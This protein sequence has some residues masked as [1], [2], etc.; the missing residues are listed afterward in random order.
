LSDTPVDY[1]SALA[2]GY[3][4]IRDV[5]RVTGV[6]PVTL[7]AWER[8]Y[9]LVVPFRTPKG[10]RLYAPEQVQLIQQVLTWL[11]RGVAVG[12]VKEL[13]EQNTTPET[14]GNGVWDE[15][16]Q[17]M[18]SSVARQAERS[19]DEA[20]NRAQSLYPP[21]ILCSQLLLPLLAELDRR[22]RDLPFGAQL[23]QVFFH[24]WLRSKLGARLYHD[25]RQQQRR[26]VVL[27][28]QSGLYLE[29]GLWLCAWLISSAGY[30]VQ[31]LD[32]AVPTSELVQAVDHIAP[33]ALLLYSSQ[34]LAAPLRHQLPRLLEAC[35]IP[36]LLAGPAATIHA[37]EL[38][39][40]H[41]AADPLL[42]ELRLRELGLLEDA[43]CAS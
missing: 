26:A 37:E 16:R 27:A 2:L 42:A 7:R 41:L 31:V 17:T 19:L 15:L 23:E 34:A 24:S 6:N 20:F 32:W 13:L 18:L 30:P 35:A 12:Q 5:A 33:R 8:R 9:G 14:L 11:N 22:W 21:Q 43:P 1:P 40:L 4:P 10:H 39:G 28:S 29:P 3:L 25:N 36:V 38:P